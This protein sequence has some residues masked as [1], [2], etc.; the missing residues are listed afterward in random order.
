MVFINIHKFL[1]PVFSQPHLTV[2]SDLEVF[3][4]KPVLKRVYNMTMSQL[5]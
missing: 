2:I 1:V 4:F 5:T 3:H